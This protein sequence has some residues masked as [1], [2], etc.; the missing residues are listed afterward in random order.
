MVPA[1]PE[2][3][4][5]NR[6]NRLTMTNEELV[7]AIQEGQKELAA[8]LWDQ[9][10]A[11]IHAKAVSFFYSKGRE[12]GLTVADLEQTGFLAMI[13]AADH[14]EQDRGN[15][16]SC[17]TVYLYS[18]FYTAAGFRTAKQVCDPINSPTSI[19]QT[20]NDDDDISIIDLQQSPQ[21]PIAEAEERI[22]NEQLRADLL[23][24]LARLPEP[25]GYVIQQHYLEGRELADIALELDTTKDSLRRSETTAFRSLRHN[26]R[27]QEHIDA[28]TP[29]YLRTRRGSLVSPVEKLAE[30]R[31][32]LRAQE[33][34]WREKWK[35]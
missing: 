20:V 15:F 22:Y 25:Q 33:M 26:T 5:D 10:K 9:V 34:K 29:F 17:L 24:E 30:L 12:R 4:N 7:Q 23:R 2:D 14:Y 3:K 19:Y 27:L 13:D 32:R 21:D 16:L 31:E 11:W 1:E 28:L 6:K 18:S 8:V 35:R